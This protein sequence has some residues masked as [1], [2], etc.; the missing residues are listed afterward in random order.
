MIKHRSFMCP[1]SWR[2][3]IPR[4]LKAANKRNGQ[5]YK[6]DPDNPVVIA[7]IHRTNRTIL[8]TARYLGPKLREIHAAEKTALHEELEEV[9]DAP[10]EGL[11]FKPSGTDAP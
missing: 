8:E 1:W 9:L 11:E 7:R 3:T 2:E 6:S 4:G 10:P 5:T